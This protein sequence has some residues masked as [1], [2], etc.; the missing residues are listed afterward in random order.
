MTPASA[1]LAHAN[2][3]LTNGQRFFTRMHHTHASHTHI[4][5]EGSRFVFV[6]GPDDP[7]LGGTLPQPALP[8]YFSGEITRVLPGAIFTTNPCRCVLG[9]EGLCVS[10]RALAL[11]AAG[12]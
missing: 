6:P 12:G 1:A 11:H 5:Q 3:P 7:G 4:Q 10:T 8:T 9:Y 2:L